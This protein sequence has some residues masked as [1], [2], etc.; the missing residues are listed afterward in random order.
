MPRP[1]RTPFALLLLLLLLGISAQAQ[2]PVR[3]DVKREKK[4]EKQEEKE[5]KKEEKELRKISEDER[6]I[7]R[8]YFATHRL[9]ARPLPPGIAKNLALGK[10]LPP[11]ISKRY[12]PQPVLERLPV[13]PGYTRYIVGG[14]IV[15]LDRSGL[16]VDIAV[17]IFK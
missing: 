3:R 13:Y 4:A 12:L 16:V 14:N 17:D 5:Q 6:R 11:G 10:P 7:L 2:G 8:D 9:A 1:A 15:L